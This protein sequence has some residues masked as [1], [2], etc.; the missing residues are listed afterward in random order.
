MYSFLYVAYVIC[1][2]IIVFCLFYWALRT[3]QFKDQQRARF[4]P[5]VKEERPME[6]SGGAGSRGRGLLGLLAAALLAAAVVIAYALAR[7]E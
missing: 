7:T 5:L 1:A 4:L 6:T 2:S 3:G